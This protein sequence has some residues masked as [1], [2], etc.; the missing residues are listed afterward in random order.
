MVSRTL[1]VAHGGQ[2]LTPCRVALVLDREQGNGGAGEARQVA[3]TE[4]R[5]GLVV[6]PLQS[7]IEV[8]A[9][10]HGEP[11]HPVWVRGVS[12]DVH[13]DLVASTSELTVRRSP[14][15]AETVEHVPE[16]GWKAGTMQS[17]AM[18]PSVAPKGGIGVVIHLSKISEKGIN[19]SSIEQRQQT[20]IQNKPPRQHVNSD[21]DSDQ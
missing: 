5:E 2:A 19:I 15:V 21:S 6:S 12:R 3:I 16:Q 1:G 9:G 8:V 17:V 4:L 10:S 14:R 11:G 20:R 18:K 7:V 13:V